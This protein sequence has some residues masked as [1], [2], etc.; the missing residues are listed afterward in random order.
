[1]ENDITSPTPAAETDA[2]RDGVFGDITAVDRLQCACAAHAPRLEFTLAEMQ[3]VSGYI[4]WLRAKSRAGGNPELFRREKP[5][6]SAAP[7]KD[8]VIV[9][10]S[11]A[12]T[13]IENAMHHLNEALP[14]G[15]RTRGELALQNL[16][17]GVEE[18]SVWMR[19]RGYTV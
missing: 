10:Y 18:L 7:L 19:A 11:T 12:G 17:R 2:K 3:M 6:I 1:M 16:R 9:D 15:Q 4:E 14:T 8:S 13:R 5:S